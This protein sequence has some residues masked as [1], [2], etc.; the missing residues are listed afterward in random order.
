MCVCVCV[1]QSRA[2]FPQHL[3][4]FLLT[5]TPI[6]PL[7]PPPNSDLMQNPL[8]VPVKILRGHAITKEIG[9][10]SLAWHPTQPWLFSCGA[11]G[12]VLLFQDVY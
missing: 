4:I 8:I 3:S 9:V 12:R 2:Q 5:P 7:A 11:D 10:M 1:P 6:P